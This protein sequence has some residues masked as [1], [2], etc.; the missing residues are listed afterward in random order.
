MEGF[1][2]GFEFPSRPLLTQSERIKLIRAAQLIREAVQSTDNS[3]PAAKDLSV[4]ELN[5]SDSTPL[6]KLAA[7]TLEDEFGVNSLPSRLPRR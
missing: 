2:V 3:A 7:T 6:L 5:H 1:M 4:F